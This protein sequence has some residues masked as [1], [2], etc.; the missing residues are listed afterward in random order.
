MSW[1]HK[2]SRSVSAHPWSATTSIARSAPIKRRIANWLATS[3]LGLRLVLVL[4][5]PFAMMLALQ[6][7]FS[8]LATLAGQWVLG[9]AVHPRGA[10][11]LDRCWHYVAVAVVILLAA[12]FLLAVFRSVPRLTMTSVL[13]GT[14]D[15]DETTTVASHR[16]RQYLSVPKNFGLMLTSAFLG[17]LLGLGLADSPQAKGVF[18]QIVLMAESLFEISMLVVAYSMASA[19]EGDLEKMGPTARMTAAENFLQKW[20]ERFS[21]TGRF[22]RF[23]RPSRRTRYLIWSFAENPAITVDLLCVTVVLGIF[24]GITVS[25]IVS[26]LD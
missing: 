14:V 6:Q 5:V 19:I 12:I 15:H 1:K 26:P 22:E 10:S 2:S 23:L 9:K 13:L 20:S 11:G 8:Y 25:W 7:G 16:F 3:W 24:V 17:A 4:A 18:H 21:R